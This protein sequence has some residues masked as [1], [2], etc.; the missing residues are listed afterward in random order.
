MHAKND[1]QTEVQIPVAL[2]HVVAV[3]VARAGGVVAV[4]IEFANY[5]HEV[6]AEVS[7]FIEQYL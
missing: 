6:P 2:V 4:E 7:Y 5:K 1:L 3:A